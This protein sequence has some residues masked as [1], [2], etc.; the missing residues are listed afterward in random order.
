M[1]TFQPIIVRLDETLELAGDTTC[2]ADH[3][4]VDSYT[5]GEHEFRLPDGVDYDLVLTNAG[6]GILVPGRSTSTICSTSP[7]PSQMTTTRRRVSTTPLS[8]TST[9]SMWPRP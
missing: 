2:L 6:E 1:G 7:R 5:L 3:I 9:R 4:D 8:P